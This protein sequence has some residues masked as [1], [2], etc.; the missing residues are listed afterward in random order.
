M[1]EGVDGRVGRGVGVLG[2]LS[3]IVV[4]RCLWDLSHVAP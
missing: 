4:H 3:L 2:Y 1:G